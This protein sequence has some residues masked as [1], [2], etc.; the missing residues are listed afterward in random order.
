MLHFY[1]FSPIEVLSFSESYG[2]TF[3]GF[4]FKEKEEKEKLLKEVKSLL[5]KWDILTIEAML[6]LLTENICFVHIFYK[7]LIY[8][9][10]SVTIQEYLS[11]EENFTPFIGKFIS[12]LSRKEET[13]LEL[14]KQSNLLDFLSFKVKEKAES[15]KLTKQAKSLETFIDFHA[16]DKAK[17]EEEEG[18]FDPFAET[19]VEDLEET[20]FFFSEPL[21]KLE[22][23]S[24]FNYFFQEEL[25]NKEIVKKFPLFKGAEQDLQ[26]QSLFLQFSSLEKG[27]DSGFV[28]KSW[29][30][31][32]KE[33]D[34]LTFLSFTNLCQ[35]K[36]WEI[37]NE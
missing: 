24:W 12:F 14:L 8:K 27:I 10:N 15:L 33:V 23:Y 16:S 34:F 21:A 5:D 31:Y 29:E 2:V 13:S 9:L 25:V 7:G 19:S 17:K 4:F 35:S 30:L 32:K 22:D 18:A 37:Y 20:D 36:L 11:S 28:I 1:T 6:Q 3:I 26:M